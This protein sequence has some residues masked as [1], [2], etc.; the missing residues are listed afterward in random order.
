MV[1]VH[2]EELNLVSSWPFLAREELVEASPS[3]TL[4]TDSLVGQHCP[5]SNRVFSTTWHKPRTPRPAL[6]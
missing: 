1:F 6:A 3:V 5:T 2:P 4:G